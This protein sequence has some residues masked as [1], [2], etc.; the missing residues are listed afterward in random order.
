MIGKG[1]AFIFAS[2]HMPIAGVVQQ[3][4]AAILDE[5]IEWDSRETV[6]FHW[7]YYSNFVSLYIKSAQEF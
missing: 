3:M 7:K 4:E 6:Y 1:E 2:L 5:F